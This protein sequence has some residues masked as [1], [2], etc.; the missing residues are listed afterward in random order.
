ME[1]SG[2]ALG[3]SLQIIKA[4]YETAETYRRLEKINK[5]A[6][7][8]IALLI[9]IK[10]QIQQSRRMENNPIVE[11]YLTDINNRL[12]KIKYLIDNVENQN[13]LK[14][15]MFTRKIEKHSKI[16]GT[17]IK[18][19]KFIIEI[20]KDMQDSAKLDVANIIRDVEARKFWESN[21]GSDH[22]YVQ[23][24]LFFSA[25]RM[26][27]QLLATEIDFLKKVINSDS[28][29][30]ISAFEFQEWIDFFGDF[31][32]VMRRT[33]DS[34]FD[35][36]T[37]EIVD[38]YYASISKSLV[39]ALLLEKSFIIRKHSNQKSVF[40]VNFKI[41]DQ[42]CQLFIYN[43][44]NEF[45]IEKV[46]D[47]SKNE[48]DIFEKLDK[49]KSSNLRELAALIEIIINPKGATIQQNWEEERKELVDQPINLESQSFLEIP[50]LNNITNGIGNIINTGIESV[51]GIIGCFTSR[52]IPK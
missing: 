18:Q 11:N 12:E 32:V 31:S 8:E 42:I 51:T 29:K 46:G 23:E 10:D 48:L 2:G 25:I 16:I 33:I 37:Y 5:T 50:T 17:A 39:R 22:T 44:N 6:L 38:W 20:K 13:F 9:T 27:T 28:D 4:I 26:H 30:Y 34:L 43:K 21:F 47:M 1:G 14:K 41:G 45:H 15:I 19:L 52:I 49:K 24:T 35:A 40:V 3:A 36:N 7:N